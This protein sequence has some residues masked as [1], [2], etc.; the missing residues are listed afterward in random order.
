MRALWRNYSLSIVA[1]LLFLAGLVGFAVVKWFDYRYELSLNGANIDAGNYVLRLASI[2]LSN[3]QSE[4]LN[5]LAFVVLGA[6]FVHKNSSQSRDSMDEVQEALA[7]I[8]RRLDELSAAE[9][10]SSPAQRRHPS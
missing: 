10:T 2:V 5:V 4:L 7:R 3:W 6:L 9:P 8:E 1:G